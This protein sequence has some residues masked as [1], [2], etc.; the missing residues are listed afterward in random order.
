MKNYITKAYID[1]LID[2]EKQTGTYF[3]AP[4]VVVKGDKYR[5][6][7]S[8]TEKLLYQEFYDITKKAAHDN[9]VD[10]YGNVYVEVSYIFLAVAIGVS[11]STIYRILSDKKNPLYKL[12]LLAVK[13][14]KDKSTSQYYVMAPVYE[15]WD[16]IFLTGD[17]STPSMRVKAKEMV[18]KKN[19]KKV[20]KRATENEQIEEEKIFDIPEERAEVKVVAKE[21]KDKM[22]DFTSE[23]KQTTE[24]DVDIDDV[25]LNNEYQ[26]IMKEIKI[27]GVKFHR[28]NLMQQLS[29]IATNH[30]GRGKKITEAKV[31][32]LAKLKSA[33][34]EMELTLQMRG[35]M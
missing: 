21:L 35:I 32:D 16:E 22:P 17:L 24:V 6:A 33:H 9:Q 34:S 8:P 26:T 20:S 11:D 13:K 27:M 1:L 25:E 2:K 31:K 19:R 5:E 10:M 28:A 7:L 14:R 23:E 15:G 18:E 3:T 12:G 4:K 30:I 29:N